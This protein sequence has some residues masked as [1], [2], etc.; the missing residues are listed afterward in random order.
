M[1][2]LILGF[3]ARPLRIQHNGPR[4][5]VLPLASLIF[6]LMCSPLLADTTQV[7]PVDLSAL[8]LEELMN[9]EITSVSKKAEPI[10]SAAAAVFVLTADDIQ[11]SGFNSIPEL[12]RLVPGLQVAKI[13]LSDWAISAR[14][15][16]GQFASKLL[17]MV[18]GRSVYSPCFS[19][20]FWDQ[21]SMP[22]EDIARIEV[23]RGPG[24]T[25]GANAVNGVINIITKDARQTQGGVVNAAAGNNEK[26]SGSARYG[27][28]LSDRT[29]YRAYLSG[30]DRSQDGE[31]TLTGRDDYWNDLRIGLRLDHDFSPRTQLLLEG[32][33]Y[34]LN[35]RHE[36]NAPE[37]TA[38]YYSYPEMDAYYRG[39]YSIARLKRQLSP[40][41]DATLQA[42]M[43]VTDGKTLF[44]TEERSTIDVEFKHS[45]Q[46]LPRNTFVWGLGYRNSQD[47]LPGLTDPERF[48]LELFNA[49]G[50]N[51]WNVIPGRLRLIAG[52]KFEHN[53]YTKWEIQPSVRT[54]WSPH[55]NHTIWAS[56]SRAVRTPSRGERSASIGLVT[57]P[58]MSALNPSPLPILS[59]V[60]GS[61][62]FTSEKLNAYEIGWRSHLNRITNASV[63][64]FYN[65][66]ADFRSATYGAPI[67][68]L[69]EPVPYM[70]L[71]VVLNNA[72][73]NSSY[74]C[75]TAAEFRLDRFWRLIASYSYLHQQ[76]GA[77]QQQTALGTEFIYPKHQA[78]LRNSFDIGRH[79]RLDAD[80]RYVSKLTNSEIGEYY[81]ADVRIGYLPVE[82][83]EVFLVGQNLFEEYHQEFGTPIAFQSLPA[84]IERT[85]Y[86][87][88]RWNF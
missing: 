36:V 50:Q 55:T 78:V 47:F 7:D 67:P 18:D 37:L 71:P 16:A 5:A 12:L 41:S 11:R 2:P 70:L 52:S 35:T 30:F 58:P 85:V 74:G 45:L 19:G 80:A 42:Y 82:S 88:T 51:E 27:G 1:N 66:Y 69:T 21:L 14:G 25:M 87:G 86:I 54:V 64:V 23:I 44:Y 60:T 8:S 28:K 61:D 43:D 24:A 81:T 20:V 65:D 53:T 6:I 10:S 75:E 31:A 59:A 26:I 38:P 4:T 34:D 63:D 48:T 76:E 33:W 68:M 17:V 46:P 15:Y 84:Q 49:F 22:L 40:T 62:D 32:N 73:E 9:I 29:F 57:I 79:V 72:S 77:S 39:V 13:D 83:V 56:A 3:P